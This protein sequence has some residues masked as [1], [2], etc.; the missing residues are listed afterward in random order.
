MIGGVGSSSRS[1]FQKPPG[2]VR[3]HSHT[4]VVRVGLSQRLELNTDG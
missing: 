2:K 1:F 4:V 3:S